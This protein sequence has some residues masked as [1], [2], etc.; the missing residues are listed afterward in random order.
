MDLSAHV[1]IVMHLLQSLK[2]RNMAFMENMSE[3][4]WLENSSP[5]FVRDK[6]SYNT[7][8]HWK[9]LE[10]RLVNFKESISQEF[11]MYLTSHFNYTLIYYLWKISIVP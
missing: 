11:I 8:K 4:P 2:Q 10:E 9:K 7:K 3:E 5:Q 6:T 1:Y